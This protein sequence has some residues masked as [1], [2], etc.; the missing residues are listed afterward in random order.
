MTSPRYQHASIAAAGLDLLHM[1]R[2]KVACS[3]LM[4]ERVHAQLS[5]WPGAGIRLLV[6]GVDTDEGARAALQGRETGVTVLPIARGV[7]ADADILRHGATVKELFDRLLLLL[8][9][10][11]MPHEPAAAPPPLATVTRVEAARPPHARRLLDCVAATPGTVTLLESA[12][13]RLAIDRGRGVVHLARAEDASAL[14]A[15]C[16]RVG[17]RVE[18]RAR[19]AF[20]PVAEGLPA[21]TPLE[22]V[23]WQAAAAGAEPVGEYP[24]GAGLGLSGWPTLDAA[25]FPVTWLLPV[26]CLL[27][28]PWS[29]AALAEACG[30]ADSDIARLFAAVHHSG[31]AV[32]GPTRTSPATPAPPPVHSP[33]TGSLL[34]RVARR[35]GLQFGGSRG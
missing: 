5:A 28:R 32:A 17:W 33:Q 25:S 26:A 8:G 35:F 27:Q 19:T 12:D 11:A 3:L 18:Q 20:D 24:D 2:L 29:A 16:G 6:A 31:L 1:T 34:A 30:A 10:E 21:A 4:A 9:D 22:T 23:V 13:L 15:A 14:I 7:H